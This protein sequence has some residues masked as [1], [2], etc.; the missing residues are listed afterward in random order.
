LIKVALPMSR[1][2]F[3]AI[4][5][6]SSFAC[7]FF[8]EEYLKRS[9]KTAR[10]L[11]LERGES[12]GALTDK[13]NAYVNRTPEKPWG[14]QLSFGG[15]SNTWWACTPRMLPE[16]F[17]LQSTFGVGRDWPVSYDEL[18]PY[19][20][21]VEERMAVAGPSD[22]SPFPRSRPYPQPPHLLTDPDKLLKKAF[23]E[24][25]YCL[26]AARPTIETENRAVCCA[27]GVCDQ[28]PIDATFN[29]PNE[30]SGLFNDPRVELLLGATVKNVEIEGSVAK[31]VV[32]E[33]DGQEHT[34]HAD[35]VVLGANAIF[36]PALML[37][38]GLQ[39]PL[40]GRRLHEQAS[41]FVVIDLDGVENFQ[42][43]TSLTGHGYMLYKDRDRSKLPAALIET[44]NV[45]DLRDTRGK[46]RQRLTIKVVFEDLASE[47]SYVG[48]DPVTG[49]PETVFHGPSEY[50]HRGAENLERDL[51]PFFDALPVDSYSIQRFPLPTDWHILGTTVMGDDP[52]DSVIDRHLLHHQVRNLVVAGS[53][54][55]PTAAPANPTPTLC[56][57]S[58]WS[59]RHLLG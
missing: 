31:G 8:L 27:A 3:D 34:A 12:S 17:R 59:A 56:A 46:W 58:I 10:V 41:R 6:G 57:L 32:Y 13:D 2:S 18:E 28:C 49:M 36:N 11:V 35:L 25:F 42:G 19:Y 23:P 47:Q 4:F 33:K 54:A 51:Q 20:C 45:P 44:R 26:P 50:A 40:L 48:V 39:H 22:D 30:M 15:A 1:E 52:A 14:T 29:I 55:F 21:E 53:G 24:H 38:S 16:D 7:S 5:V 43:S 9:S 37:S